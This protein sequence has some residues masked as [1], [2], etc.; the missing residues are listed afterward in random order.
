MKFCAFWK[1]VKTNKCTELHEEIIIRRCVIGQIGTG[2]YWK[3]HFTHFYPFFVNNLLIINFKIK[4]KCT[5]INMMK[6]ISLFG[7]VIWVISVCV[8]K[9]WPLQKSLTKWAAQFMHFPCNVAFLIRQDTTK[10]L[11]IHASIF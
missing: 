1:R 2:F 8:Y 6:C 11:N 5:T 3:H 7:F 4:V 9:L 10:H